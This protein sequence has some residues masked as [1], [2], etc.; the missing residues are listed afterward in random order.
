MSTRLIAFVALVALCAPATASPANA[1]DAT[2]RATWTPPSLDTFV[3]GALGNTCHSVHHLTLDDL[4]KVFP[5][6]GSLNGTLRGKV[7]PQLPAHVQAGSDCNVCACGVCMQ[8]AGVVAC[9]A[10][11]TCCASGYNC[12]ADCPA[13]LAH[14]VIDSKCTCTKPPSLNVGPPGRGTTA[15]PG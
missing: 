15:R 13:D 2:Q 10:C 12:S 14:Q 5:V 1:P 4:S 11:F 8:A 7:L 9:S 3:D 6:I